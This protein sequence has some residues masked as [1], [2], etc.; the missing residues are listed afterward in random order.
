MKEHPLS[1]SSPPHPLPLGPFLS[2]LQDS[3]ACSQ[4]RTH[5]CAFM[6]Y[7]FNN[8][9]I[10]C[11]LVYKVFVQSGYT[12]LRSLSPSPMLRLLT[13]TGRLPRSC[14]DE[15]VGGD[16]IAGAHGQ[17]SRT[18]SS[19]GTS[20]LLHHRDALQR[21]SARAA[22]NSGCSRPSLSILTASRPYS[23]CPPWPTPLRR[24]PG[25]TWTS[26]ACCFYRSRA[27]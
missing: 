13:E 9:F 14:S 16:E 20:C 21:C 11:W 4:G 2:S 7:V 3:A 8:F 26:R 24:R 5:G 22:S 17:R 19:A 6:F 15:T 12:A 10:C 1:L 18:S 23:R 25:P 27:R